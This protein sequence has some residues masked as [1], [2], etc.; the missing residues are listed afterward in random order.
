MFSAPPIFRLTFTN[1]QFNFVFLTRGLRLVFF[2]VSRF[3]AE[4]LEEI[5]L[6]ISNHF[7]LKNAG[8]KPCKLRTTLTI[9]L[10][11]FMLTVKTIKCPYQKVSYHQIYFD[12]STIFKLY[13]IT[14]LW[15]NK[16]FNMTM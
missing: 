11:S 15:L 3:E 14:K 2:I 5:V 1:Q 4:Y 10:H 16:E 13:S 6:G 12:N 9:F 8:D 7:I